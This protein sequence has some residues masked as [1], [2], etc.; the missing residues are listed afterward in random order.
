MLQLLEQSELDTVERRPF[1]YES[2]Q[3]SES[4]IRLLEIFPVL[5]D[6][7]IPVQ[8]SDYRICESDRYRCL[9]YMWGRH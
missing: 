1:V 4:S 2:L 5:N 9:S 7:L 8:L 3:S 6:S